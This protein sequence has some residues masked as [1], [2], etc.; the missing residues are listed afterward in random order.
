MSRIVSTMVKL[1]NWYVEDDK[2]INLREEYIHVYLMHKRT[3][4][5]W[6]GVSWAEVRL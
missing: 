2:L 3:E 5:R 1:A 6:N 4:F